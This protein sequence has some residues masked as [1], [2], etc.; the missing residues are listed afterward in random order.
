MGEIYEYAAE[1]S[2]TQQADPSQSKENII[3]G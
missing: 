3:L 1:Q 2:H